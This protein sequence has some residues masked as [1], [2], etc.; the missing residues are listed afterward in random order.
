MAVVGGAGVS[1]AAAAGSSGRFAAVA[2]RGAPSGWLAPHATSKNATSDERGPNGRGRSVD[3][4]GTV[5]PRLA[6]G[7]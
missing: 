1:A 3:M 5:A 4:R 6:G 7:T 2:A